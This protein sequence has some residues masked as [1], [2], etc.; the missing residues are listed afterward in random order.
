MEKI[1]ALQDR[2]LLTEATETV[3]LATELAIHR[4]P[5]RMQ[6]FER[7]ANNT[8]A[9]TQKIGRTTKNRVSSSSHAPFLAHVDYETP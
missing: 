9:T 6:D 3:A 1:E 8:L 2:D 4:A 7:S 5:T